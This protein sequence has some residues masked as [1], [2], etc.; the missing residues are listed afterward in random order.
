MADHVA[1][2]ADGGIDGLTFEEALG[3]LEKIVHR[4]EAGEA[5]LEESIDLYNEGA[6][7]KAHCEAKLASAQARIEK[8]QLGAD[9]QP[10]GLAPFDAE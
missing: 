4:L 3:R 9:G 7:L 2:G 6:R 1:N 5:S 10:S 8:I